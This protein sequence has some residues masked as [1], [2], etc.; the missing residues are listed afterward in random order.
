MEDPKDMSR[1]T[2]LEVD[3]RDPRHAKIVSKNTAYL[4]A[5]RPLHE[6]ERAPELK[7]LSLYDFFRFWRIELAA[8]ALSDADIEW[9]DTDACHAKLTEKGWNKIAKSRY[10]SNGAAA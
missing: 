3:L 10:G 9:E 1:K 4:Y 6:T 2:R 8:Y 7:F 5:M